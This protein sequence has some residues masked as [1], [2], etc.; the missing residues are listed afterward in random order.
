MN[1][2]ISAGGVVIG[3]NNQ[4]AVVNQNNDSWSLPKG[5][6]NK[7]ETL[8]TAARRE[9]Y[10]E[11]GLKPKNLKLLK[12]LGGYERHTIAKN[13][14]GEDKT[15]LKRIHMFLFTTNQSELSPTDPHNPEAIWLDIDQVC[16][17]LT[18]PKD[19]KFFEKIKTDIN[20]K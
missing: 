4:I 18:H 8:L 9:I 7:G 17:K 10:E 14:Q 12:K 6:I 1:K 13:G 3:P 5:H 15:E 19:K 2:S 11:A 16:A 20:Q